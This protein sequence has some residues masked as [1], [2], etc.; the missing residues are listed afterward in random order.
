MVFKAERSIAIPTQDLISW[1]FDKDLDQDVPV[2]P[3][4]ESK[5][6]EMLL[7]MM[8]FA[9]STH[10]DMSTLKIHQDQFLLD[11]LAP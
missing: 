4:L 11:K 9:N 7:P 1:T 5:K 8:H 2:S 6:S 3:P 10:R